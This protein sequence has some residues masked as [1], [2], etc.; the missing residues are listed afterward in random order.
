[1]ANEDK[2]SDKNFRYRDGGT[3]ISLAE[4]KR[5]GWAKK[6]DGTPTAWYTNIQTAKNEAKDRLAAGGKKRKKRE[7]IPQQ[8]HATIESPYDLRRKRSGYAT[9][10]MVLAETAGTLVPWDTLSIEVN[11]RLAQNCND[12]DN[13]WYEKN[14]A[15]QKNDDGTQKVYDV[16]YNA[17]VISR[18]PY[19]VRVEELKQRVCISEHGVTLLTNV[20]E[21]KQRKKRVAKA[22]TAVK[23]AEA[24]AK[25]DAEEAAQKRADEEQKKAAEEQEKREKRNARRRELTAQKKLATA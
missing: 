17:Y 2:P 23:L 11:Q 25:A 20:T 13:D 6:S 21:P 3:M 1:M 9:I 8:F 19:D 4:A 7:A 24:Q 15:S 16:R 18:H 12:H 5:R 10:W 14:Y 22:D